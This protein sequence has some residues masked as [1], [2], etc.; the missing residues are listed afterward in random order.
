[1]WHE[2][3]RGHVAD[4]RVRAW[5]PHVRARHGRLPRRHRLQPHQPHARHGPGDR[6]V[7]GALH[8]GRAAI[9]F[10]AA[11]Q[12]RDDMDWAAID[13]DTSDVALPLGEARMPA[14]VTFDPVNVL[15]LRF[16]A[17]RYK[18]PGTRPVEWVVEYA[19]W[20]PTA[21][22]VLLPG[23]ATVTWSDEPG[24][25]FR[26][27]IERANPG[28]DVSSAMARGR[29]LLAQAAADPHFAGR[30]DSAHCPG[31]SRA[32]AWRAYSVG[33]APGTVSGMMVKPQQTP[34]TGLPRWEG[35]A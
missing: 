23:V 29:T 33:S 28:A 1:M 27:W 8:V 12:G 19:G 9:L 31:C 26:M 34:D 24:P 18:G 21:D 14:R 30:A 6:P 17:E 5:A 16:S 13:D 20:K 2:L 32:V 11:W 4:L 15:P 7:V 3:G 25:W 35:G 22:G 10:R